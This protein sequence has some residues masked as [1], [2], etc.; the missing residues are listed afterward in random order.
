MVA[1]VFLNLRDLTPV[2]VP[3]AVPVLSDGRLRTAALAESAEHLTTAALDEW[4]NHATT[5]STMD[6]GSMK[7]TWAATSVAISGPLCCTVRGP[8]RQRVQW[9]TKKR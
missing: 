5:V 1:R 8:K 7:V 3:V 4:S 6:S 2:P 9:V